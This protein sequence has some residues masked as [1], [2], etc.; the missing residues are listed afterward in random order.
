M[1]LGRK[2]HKVLLK[3]S[4]KI[5]LEELWRKIYLG[6]PILAR[7]MPLLGKHSNIIIAGVADAVFFYEGPQ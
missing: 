7:E 5:K 1:K 2:V 4:V 3:G 6:G